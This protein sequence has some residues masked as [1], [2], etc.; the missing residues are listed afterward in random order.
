MREPFHGHKLSSKVDCALRISMCFR[1]LDKIEKFLAWTTD[2]VEFSLSECGTFFTS[3]NGWDE[4]E[5]SAPST[6]SPF[7]GAPKSLMP[8]LMFL[9]R[10]GAEEDPGPDSVER[11]QLG[12]I[13]IN[14]GTWL[15][16]TRRSM[17][18]FFRSSQDPW[19][20]LDSREPCID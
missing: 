6:P 16:W 13:R 9:H 10:V 8:R 18:F 19:N 12:E 1:R 20:P 17:G 5:N 15:L 14:F 2:G 3:L 7:C 11:Y 4:I